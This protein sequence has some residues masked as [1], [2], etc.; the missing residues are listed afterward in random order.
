ML[1]L[2][3]LALYTPQVFL[4]SISLLFVYKY[5]YFVEAD[6]TLKLK[7]KKLTAAVFLTFTTE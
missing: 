6:D 4:F 2:I 5:H 3:G 1:L 7:F